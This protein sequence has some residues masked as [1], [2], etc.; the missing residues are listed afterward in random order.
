MRL[1]ERLLDSGRHDK[2]AALDMK[3]PHL[4]LVPANVY[5]VRDN[6]AHLVGAAGV[7]ALDREIVANVVAMFRMGEEYLRF[8]LTLPASEWRHKVSRLYYAA[9]ALTRAVRF[10]LHGDWS[11]SPTEHQIVGKLPNGFPNEHTYTNRLPVLRKDR[12]L[13][14][15]DHSG[16]PGDLVISVSDAEA[17]VKQLVADART[18][19]G[20]KGITV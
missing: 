8:A 7:A 1:P 11:T 6:V 5:T 2:R 3:T 19:L 10:Q 17:L 12:N 20:Y 13:A 16:T 4:L 14:D 9:Y 18:F 15:Y